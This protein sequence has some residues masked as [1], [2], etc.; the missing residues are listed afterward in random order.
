MMKAKLLPFLL[1][2]LIASC[3]SA[4]M[5]NG[6]YYDGGYYGMVAEHA[7]GETENSESYK[8]IEEKDFKTPQDAP[9]SSFSLD[10]S[11]A[12]YSNIRRHINEGYAI[13]SDMVNIEQMINYFDY[14]DYAAPTDAPVALYS[15]TSACPWNTK[16]V[17]TSVAVKTKK[18]DYQ[19]TSGNNYVLLIDVSGSMSS[20]NKLPLVKRGFSMLVDGLNAEDRVSIVTYSG[21]EAVLLDGGKGS[22]KTKIKSAINKLSAN[23]S[24]AGQKGIEM[25]YNLIDKYYIQGGNNQILLATDGDFNVGVSDS[26]T[27]GQMVLAK[28]EKGVFFSCFGFGMGNYKSDTMEELAL[29]G[30]GN[31][32]YID[33]ELEMERTFGGDISSVLQ[34]VAK[35]SKIQ[36]TFDEKK[37]AKYRLIGYENRMMTDEEF[38]DETKDAGEIYSNRSV[39]ALY[40]IIPIAEDKDKLINIDFKYKDPKNNESFEIKQ[41]GA[42]FTAD[43]S[44]SF[45]FA[46]MVAEFGLVLRDSKYKG[47]AST[48]SIIARYE[49][50]KTTYDEDPLRQDFLKLV[51]KWQSNPNRK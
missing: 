36:I 17:L 43:P 44:H 50:D 21:K 31:V 19:N 39:V 35:D 23:G 15:E 27:L 28:K 33:D 10:S 14:D 30:N 49:D 22:D 47:N 4:N 8:K 1:L 13:S 42:D 6:A 51:K 45:D 40:E 41:V 3:S 37:V 12:A 29:N 24:T 20:S 2:P 26:T 34:V 11:G 48:S 25:A 7:E 46:N 32:F 9:T 38:N 16:A 18:V 5:K